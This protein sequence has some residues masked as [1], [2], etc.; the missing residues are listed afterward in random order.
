MST[1]DEVTETSPS[2]GPHCT[3]KCHR[4]LGG[5]VG[6]QEAFE[7]SR[8]PDRRTVMMWRSVAHRKGKSN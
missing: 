1:A 5:V 4:E 2:G 7:G 3:P 8:F 6:P